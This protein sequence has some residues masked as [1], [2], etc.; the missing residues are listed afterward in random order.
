M[1]TFQTD[2]Y[3][4]AIEEYP[5]IL[6]YTWDGELFVIDPALS[7]LQEVDFDEFYEK[8][9]DEQ[10]HQLKLNTASVSTKLN[11]EPFAG[12]AFLLD[13]IESIDVFQDPGPPDAGP[14]S[15]AGFIFFIN[16][17]HSYDVVVDS[18]QSLKDALNSYKGAHNL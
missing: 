5:G 1:K 3:E 15:G 13:Q 17:N 7:P 8:I 16:D 6:G 9:D 14:A 4:T 10:N 11:V 18:V 12:I 2:D